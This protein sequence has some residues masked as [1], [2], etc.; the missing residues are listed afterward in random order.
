MLLLQRTNP[1]YGFEGDCCLNGIAPG[2]TPLIQIRG[3]SI[4]RSCGVVQEVKT[5]KSQKRRKNR[6]L[7]TKKH[8]REVKTKKTQKTL[9]G[10]KNK[11]T[12]KSVGKTEN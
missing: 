2:A 1:C 12:Q 8:L 6:K 10:G 9:A 4:V 5:K 7:N 3:G 11:K